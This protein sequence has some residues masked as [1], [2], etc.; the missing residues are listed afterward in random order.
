MLAALVLWVAAATSQVDHRVYLPV[1]SRAPQIE[2]SAWV[3]STL[4]FGPSVTIFGRITRDGAGM[5]DVPMSAVPECAPWSP[6]C[7]PIP[8]CYG[9]T[10]HD[11]VGHCQLDLSHAKKNQTTIVTVTMTMDGR[12]Y[13]AQTEFCFRCNR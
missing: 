9:I 11:G 2:A 5:P 10:G 4:V 7:G 6:F 12:P 1:V 8:P 3:Q 13:R